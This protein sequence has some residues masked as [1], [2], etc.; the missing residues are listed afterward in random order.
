MSYLEICIE[1]G[2][3]KGLD[4]SYLIMEDWDKSSRVQVGC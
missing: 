4:V 2:I 1:V 3:K